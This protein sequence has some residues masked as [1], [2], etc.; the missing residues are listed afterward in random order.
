MLRQEQK[1]PSVAMLDA[2]IGEHARLLTL[3]TSSNDRQFGF[4]ELLDGFVK[5]EG[6]SQTHEAEQ[7]EK[8]RGIFPEST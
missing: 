5:A 3:S 6:L 1:A 4:K 2:L 8:N 7:A